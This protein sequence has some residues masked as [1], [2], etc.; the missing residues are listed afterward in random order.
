MDG[1]DEQINQ[2]ERILQIILGGQGK[3]VCL[4][5]FF[6]HKK[7]NAVCISLDSGMTG[8]AVLSV[9]KKANAFPIFITSHRAVITHPM[10]YEKDFARFTHVLVLHSARQLAVSLD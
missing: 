3:S 10:A 7:Q 2:D 6:L 5:G 1:A 9:L 4:I 8:Q